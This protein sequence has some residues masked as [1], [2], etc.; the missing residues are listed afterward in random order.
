MNSF[1][2]LNGEG[3]QP[4]TITLAAS[5]YLDFDEYD[6]ENP[7]QELIDA[8]APEPELEVTELTI[9]TSLVTSPRLGGNGDPE[10]MELLTEARSVGATAVTHPD[11]GV[12]CLTVYSVM[13][14]N[15]PTATK[16]LLAPYINVKTT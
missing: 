10:L 1:Y 12:T 14:S 4:T 9:P 13:V 6:P 7:P 15:L 11:K 5:E 2:K 3:E 16:E 8:Q